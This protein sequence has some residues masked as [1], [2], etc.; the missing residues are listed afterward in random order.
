MKK[1][2]DYKFGLILALGFF[3]ISIYSFSQETKMSRSERKEARKAELA[4]NFNVLDTLLNAR[5]FVLKADMLENKYGDRV[6]VS[7]TINFVM[8]NGA[9]AVLQTGSVS[10]VGF[11]GVGGVTAEGTPD[12]YKVTKNLKNKTYNVKFN[13]MSNVGI[14]DIFMTVNSDLSAY[15]VISGLTADKLTYRGYLEPATGSGVFK[16]YKSY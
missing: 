4:A 2:I 8:I 9:N 11:N 3:W 7:S 15:A 1:F 16:G 12:S 5:N 13:L 10:R 14:Y 6:N